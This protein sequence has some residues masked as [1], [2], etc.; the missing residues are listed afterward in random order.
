MWAQLY[1]GNGPRK[2][3]SATAAGA[4]STAVGAAES[5]PSHTTHTAATATRR[6]STFGSLPAN[7]MQLIQML[8]MYM[9]TFSQQVRATS[10]HHF[11]RSFVHYFT[12]SFVHSLRV[13]RPQLRDLP[14]CSPLS[15]EPEAGA[16]GT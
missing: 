11:T 13:V 7:D 9:S 8:H 2:T 16:H 3:I 1:Y 4:S 6:G 10:M 5:A 15:W 14:G 12:R